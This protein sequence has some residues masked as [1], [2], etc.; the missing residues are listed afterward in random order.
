[1]IFETSTDRGI[2]LWG[3]LKDLIRRLRRLRLLIQAWP[4]EGYESSEEESDSRSDPDVDP[5]NEV[6]SVRV[7]RLHSVL[8]SEE[9]PVYGI[10]S[11]ARELRVLKLE[12]PQWDPQGESEYVRLDHAL[13]DT[14]FPHLYELALSQCAVEGDWL[15]DFLLR[16]K[17]TLRRLSMSN[18]SLPAVRPSWRDVFTRISGQ[19]PRLHKVNLHGGFH[20]EYCHPIFF[21]YNYSTESMAYTQAMEMFILRGGKYPTEHS[22]RRRARQSEAVEINRYSLSHVLSNNETLS[23]DP[24]LDY[25]PDEYDDWFVR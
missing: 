15:V 7:I 13:P 4:P 17:E 24:A 5:E 25:E 19:L 14:H 8:L 6:K 12:L 16:H 2:L 9:G 10:L 20:R 1:M 18:M 21:E 11:E 3:A 22:I 23:D